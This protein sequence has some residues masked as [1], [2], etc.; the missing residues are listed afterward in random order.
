ML[1]RRMQRIFHCIF[2]V[3]TRMHG[4]PSEWKPGAPVLKLRP[5]TRLKDKYFAASGFQLVFVLTSALGY[6]ACMNNKT[7]LST[8][9]TLGVILVT[10]MLAVTFTYVNSV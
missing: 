7:L 6:A 9:V 1:N 10:L 2:A 3:F 5:I 4:I 8:K